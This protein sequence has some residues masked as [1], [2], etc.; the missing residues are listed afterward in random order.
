MNTIHYI[1]LDVHKKSV[2]YC[3]KAAA[4]RI[5]E[6][7]KLAATRAALC[8]WAQKRPVAWHGALE[9]TLF[10]GW[11]YET[12][13]PYAAQLQ[14]GHPARMKAIGA[15]K[16]KTD[17]LDAR[18]I[19]DLVRC[20]LLPA[21]LRGASRDP[22]TAA[23]TA[24][25]QSGGVRSGAPEEQDRWAADG[26]G[27]A[28]SETALAWA[29]IFQRAVGAVGRSAAVGERLAAVESRSAGDVRSDTAAVTEKIAATSL[30]GGAGETAG[31]HSRRRSSDGPHLGFGSSR[32]TTLPL[33]GPGAELLW[34]DGGAAGFGRQSA[35]RAPLQAAQRALTDRIDRSRETGATL[36]SAVSRAARPRTGTRPSQPWQ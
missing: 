2:S 23:A 5:V 13:Q 24:L 7:G 16:K 35:A 6:E 22:G 21:C 14:M 11:I 27:R 10:S 17:Q 9:A 30:A 1:G 19:A 28:V 36:E 18:T 3:V 33:A 34:A 15:S 4:G 32:A 12:L 8:E 31:K 29:R 26:G 20:D 25:S